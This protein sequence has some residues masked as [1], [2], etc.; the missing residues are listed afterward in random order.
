MTADAGLSRELNSLQEEL[1][2]SRHTER[3]SSPADRISAS[4]ETVPPTGTPDESTEGHGLQADFRD[5]VNAITEFVDAAGKSVSLHD[6]IP[7]HPKVIVLTTILTDWV[8][9]H[10]GTLP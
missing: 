9:Y 8:R 5:F 1:S 6:C 3:L 4:G 2:T 7:I 10:S